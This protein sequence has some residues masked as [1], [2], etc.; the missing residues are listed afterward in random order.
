MNEPLVALQ[1]KGEGLQIFWEN[2]LS[3]HVV[4]VI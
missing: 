1:G 4:T 3:C 2:N